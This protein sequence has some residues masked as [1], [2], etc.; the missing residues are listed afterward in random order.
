MIMIDDRGGKEF[1]QWWRYQ[2]FRNFQWFL[3]NN[4]PKACGMPKVTE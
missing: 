4:L 3:K 1:G 2:I